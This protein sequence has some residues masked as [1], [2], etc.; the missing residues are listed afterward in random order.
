MCLLGTHFPKNHRTPSSPYPRPNLSLTHPIPVPTSLP[1]LLPG[2]TAPCSTCR[3]QAQCGPGQRQQGGSKTAA[4]ACNPCPANT[5]QSNQRH[6]ETVCI[7]VTECA[8]GSVKVTNATATSNT[9]CSS[10]QE[11][12][13]DQYEAVSPD[14]SQNQDRVCESLTTCGK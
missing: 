4:G 1:A 3:P 8:E 12:L 9:R 5:F 14:T 10:F 6:F 13:P 2:D 11:C 7:Q